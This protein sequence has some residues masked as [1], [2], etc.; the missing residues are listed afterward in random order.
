MSTM[1]SVSVQTPAPP[2]TVWKPGKVKVVRALYKYTAQNADELSFDEGEILYVYDK[3]VEPNWWRAKCGNREGL[4]PANYVEEQT[5]EIEL[6]LHDAARRGNLSLLKEY[7]KQGVSG[8]ALDTVGNT[9]LYWAARAGHID[10]V[11][12]LLNL[13]N[14][15]VNA[16]NKIG[17]TPLHIA[18]SRGHVS[19][20]NL[21]LQHDADPTIKNND[22]FVAE[23]LSSDFA[24]KNMIQLSQRE[25][26]KTY[27]YT[28]DDYNDDSD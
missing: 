9:S 12:E 10:C 14:P 2:K 1:M 21:L 27:G 23:Q 6:P 15:V 28:E 18:A 25:H 24:I 19:I 22:G 16:Q 5:E 4:V 13:P 8:T 20:I 7:L 3:D 17:E 11:K 26:D